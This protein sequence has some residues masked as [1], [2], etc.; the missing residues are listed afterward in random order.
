VRRKRR[1]AGTVGCLAVLAVAASL[2]PQILHGAGVAL[3]S[4]G[5]ASSLPQSIGGAK[6]SVLD[7]RTGPVPAVTRAGAKAQLGLDSVTMWVAPPEPGATAPRV[8]W[9]NGP[10]QTQTC[11]PLKRDSSGFLFRMA[12][13]G[14]D[15]SVA[16]MVFVVDGP[17]GHVVA[18]AEARKP[19]MRTVDLGQGYAA[20]VVVPISRLD[21]SNNHLAVTGLW[22]FDKGGRLVARYQR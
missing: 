7:P 3:P 15:E 18:E 13:K 17:V 1:L 11:A 21:D 6:R 16:P 20:V 4:A 14:H 10:S 8:C 9:Q 5:G 2:G 19:L 22:V 12:H